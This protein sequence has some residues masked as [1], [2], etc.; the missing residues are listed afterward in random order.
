MSNEMENF[1][2][3]IEIEE[4]IEEETK[5]EMQIQEKVQKQ[6]MQKQKIQKQK[7]QKQK[8]QK[9]EVQKQE[10]QKQINKNNIEDIKGPVVFNG[11]IHFS[12]YD[13]KRYEVIRYQLISLNQ[14]LT[15]K[16][17]EQERIEM[18]YKNIVANFQNE[19]QKIVDNIRNK[20]EEFKQLQKEI[21]TLY[22][23]SID[24]LSYDERS[25][26]LRV[27]GQNIILDNGEKKIQN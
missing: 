13:L 17:F 3:E 26:R 8:V 9:Q 23:L 25:G 15:L 6:K 19:N 22:N 24:N 4:E 2:E 1:V 27:N 10:A 5:E 11:C 16:K 18:Q 20:E 12:P 14:S 21:E 7:L